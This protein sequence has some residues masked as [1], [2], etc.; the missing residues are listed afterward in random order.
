MFKLVSL[1]KV[2][3]VLAVALLPYVGFSQDESLSQV[4]SKSYVFESN[5]EYVKAANVIKESKASTTYEGTLRMGWCYYLAKDYIQSKTNYEKSVA[6]MPFAIEPHLG[7]ANALA[8]LGNWEQVLE[9]YQLILKTDPQ[10]SLTLYRVGLIYYNRK[11]YGSAQKYFEKVVNLYP[12]DYD[13]TI[14]LAWTMLKLNKSIEAKVLF[15]K[16]LLMRPDDS[17]ATEGLKLIK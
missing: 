4:F 1:K 14:M 12:F 17:S 11:D 15:N 6:L 7:L 9:Q 2:L 16:T 10:N 8:G 13:S 5:S 3:T